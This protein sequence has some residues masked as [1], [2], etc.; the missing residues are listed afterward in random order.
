[1]NLRSNHD[2]RIEL[3][4]FLKENGYKDIQPYLLIEVSDFND[5]Y[6]K[7]NP[8]DDYSKGY[9][10]ATDEALKGVQKIYHSDD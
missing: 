7:N 8:S 1:M 10:D 5:R 9:K 6:E 3:S 2:K 4:K